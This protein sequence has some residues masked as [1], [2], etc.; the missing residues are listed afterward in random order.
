MNSPFGRQKKKHRS[1]CWIS[2]GK[3]SKHPYKH[4]CCK[5]GD[6]P[7]K[8]KIQKPSLRHGS[9]IR[10]SSLKFLLA[11]TP[12]SVP[13]FVSKCYGGKFS[14]EELTQHCGLLQDGKKAHNQWHY[15]TRAWRCDLLRE[16]GIELNMLRSFK[17]RNSF[18]L[19]NSW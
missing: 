15:S 5:G 6:Q 1:S 18:Q 17:E 11:V 13:S 3:N 8:K 10:A 14:G 9:S 2:F 12:N 7:T 19:K 16:Q 4:W